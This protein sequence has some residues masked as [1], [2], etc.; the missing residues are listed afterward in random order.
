L[1]TPAGSPSYLEALAAD[2]LSDRIDRAEA[3]LPEPEPAVRMLDA[4][5]AR[6]ERSKKPETPPPREPHLRS[7]STHETTAF[8]AFV[9]DLQRRLRGLNYTTVLD[10]HV[11]EICNPWFSVPQLI[12]SA[13]PGTQPGE[14]EIGWL[15]ASELKQ[16]VEACLDYEGDDSHGGGGCAPEELATYWSHVE[17]FVNLGRSTILTYGPDPALPGYFTWWYFCYLV[18]DPVARRVCLLYGVASD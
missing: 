16:S 12:A 2:D 7:I 14:R 13:Y 4:D 11:Y 9:N 15:R 5:A 1:V 10:A 8:T 17:G 6:R 3:Q 18:I